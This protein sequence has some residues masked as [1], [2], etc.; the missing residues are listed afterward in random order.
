MEEVKPDQ[1]LKKTFTT[2]LKYLREYCEK[3]HHG[4]VTDKESVEGIKSIMVLVGESARKLDKFTNL[5]HDSKV[6]RVTGLR[7]YQKL[8]E[9]YLTRIARKVDTSTLGQWILGLAQGTF[10]KPQKFETKHLYVDLESVKS[11]LDYELFFMRKE[12]GSHYFNPRLI[13]NMK[14]VCDFGDTMKQMKDTSPD[15]L[16]DLDIWFDRA[17]RMSAKSM[18]E[19]IAP[20]INW[21]YKEASSF[22]KRDFVSNMN[23]AL[24]ALIMSSH[25]R[26]LLEKEPAKCC[27]E[28]FLDFQEFLIKVLQSP[29]Y[30]KLTAYP[31]KKKNAFAVR[32]VETIHALCYGFVIAMDG[33]KMMQ[34]ELAA[35]MRKGKALLKPQKEESISG[36]LEYGYQA[37]AE[38]MKK[39]PFGPLAKVL[40]TIEGGDW[41][42]FDPMHQE[43]IPQTLY[44]FD[45]GGTSITVV[46]LPTPTRQEYLEK[47]TINEE[48]KGFLLGL[49]EKKRHGKFLLINLQ[50]RTSWKEKARCLALEELQYHPDFVNKLCVVTLS[51]DS[52]F[53]FQEGPFSH[54]NQAKTFM[55]HFLAH[56]KNEE[57]EYF[58]PDEIRE[59]LFP[60]LAEKLMHEVH[61]TYFSEKNV[62]TKAQRRVFI[63]IFYLLLQ[64]KLVELAEPSAMS[65]TCKDGIDTGGEAAVLWMAFKKAGDLEKMELCLHALPLLVRGRLMLPERFK[66][67]IETLKVVSLSHYPT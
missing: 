58:F 13:K 48:F 11:D 15:Y 53:Y 22:K 29:D 23:Q 56:L 33:F 26:N 47:V 14:L 34:P 20:Q 59:A 4:F 18:M 7:E 3:Q 1:L 42:A 12:D 60:K 27:S 57:G 44:S 36:E 19:A 31:P 63:E 55:N 52:D 41:H 16:A 37:L 65:F 17:I 62:L 51:K 61:R 30:Q 45:Q 49:A 6:K 35:L 39:H 10:A 66:S 54:V 8:Q 46:H 28:Y 43:N 64:Q 24:M 32:I 5:F 25:T 40:E 50:D 38:L 9:F 2:I 67:L 21:F